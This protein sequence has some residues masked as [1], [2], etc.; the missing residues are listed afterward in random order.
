MNSAVKEKADNLL[1]QSYTDYYVLLIKYCRIRMGE[2]EAFAAD[3]VQEAF[4]VYYNKLLKGEEI[5][6]PKAFLYRTA[7]NF[8]KKYTA[9]YQKRLKNTT[10]L[11]E[12]DLQ[13]DC[14]FSLSDNNLI[15]YDECAARLLELLNKDE[16]ELYKMKYIEK[17]SLCEIS[18]IL[19]ISGAAAAKRTSRLRAA[20]KEKLADVIQKNTEGGA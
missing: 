3:C 1:K 19:N 11:E 16:L 6:Y 2:A 7:D 13:A 17:K 15:D 12:V 10:T 14:D 20:I 9:D 4:I 8:L 5:R 18:E